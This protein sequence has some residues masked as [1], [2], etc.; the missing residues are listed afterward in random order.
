M[1]KPS[2]LIGCVLLS[3]CATTGV[4]Y[5]VDVEGDPHKVKQLKGNPNGYV[6][7]E[8]NL[9]GGWIDPEDYRRNIIAIEEA[10]G[11]KVDPTTI[12]NQGLQTTA[13]VICE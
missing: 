7:H 3:G 12:T 1:N 10:T 4:E 2:I 13:L 6:A 5:S 9:L 11:C 8:T